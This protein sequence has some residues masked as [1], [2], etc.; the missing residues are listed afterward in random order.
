LNP[1][2]AQRMAAQAAGADRPT[3]VTMPLE[4]IARGCMVRV[5]YS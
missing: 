4:M 2:M 3:P 1:S 5:F